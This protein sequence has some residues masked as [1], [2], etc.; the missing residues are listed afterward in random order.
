MLEWVKTTILNSNKK[1]FLMLPSMILASAIILTYNPF[2]NMNNINNF[3]RTLGNGILNGIDVI[4]RISSIIILDIILVPLI[5]FF[6]W[7]ILNKVCK[8]VNE[9]KQE[10]IK[11]LNVVSTI[12]IMPMA[13][14]H[15]NR[16]SNP[17]S[18]GIEVNLPCFIILYLISYLW[19]NTKNVNLNFEK[20]KWCII[21]AMPTSIFLMLIMSKMGLVIRGIRIALFLNSFMFMITNSFIVGIYFF[22]I[23]KYEKKLNFERIKKSYTLFM[24]SP[25]LVSICLEIINILNQHHIYVTSKLKFSIMVYAIM[26]IAF[27]ASYIKKCKTINKFPF[28]KYYYPIILISLSCIM[29]QPNIQSIFNTDFFEQSNHGTA[30]NQLFRFGKIPLIE[31]FD[32]HMLQNQIGSILYGILNNDYSGAV[33][34]GY[35]L[36]PIFVFIYYIL[37]AKFFDRDISFFIMMIFPIMSE[38]TFVLFPLLPLVIISFLY[39]LKNKTYLSYILYWIAIAIT[40]LFRLDMGFTLVFSTIVAWIVSYFIDKK[41]IHIKKIFISCGCVLIVFGFIYLIICSIKNISPISRVIEFLRLCQSNVNWGYSSLG[42]ISTIAF[43]TCYFMIPS[44][45]IILLF[46]LVFRKKIDKDFEFDYKTFIVLIIGLVSIFNLSRGMVRHSLAENNNMYIISSS[47]L[48]ISMI[49]YMYS[50][51]NKLLKF[52]ISSLVILIFT[53]LLID[54]NIFL[55]QTLSNSAIARYL[56]F[57]AYEDL[58]VKKV[59]RVVLSDDMKKIYEPIKDIFNNMLLKDETYIDFTNQTL[60]YAL[61]NRE[62]P[63]YINQS[64]GLLSGEYT[65]KKFIEEC[66]TNRENTPFILMPLQPMLF[67]YELD[68]IQN[69]Y[70]YY[71]VSEYISNK[72]K[73]MF[74][75]EQFTIWCRNDKFEEKLKLANDLMEKDRNKYINVNYINSINLNGINLD[76]SNNDN[77]MVLQSTNNDPILVGLENLSEI[78]KLINE[79]KFIHLY[80][81]YSSNIDGTFELFYTTENGEDFSPNKVVSKKMINKGVFEATIPC[82]QYTRIRFDIPEN[83]SVSINNIS[84]KSE[85]NMFNETINFINYDYLTLD[86]HKYNLGNIPYIWANYDKINIKDKQE[87]MILS[88]DNNMYNFNT[89][90]K[91]EGNYIYINSTSENDGTMTLQLGKNSDDNFEPLVQYN[92]QLNNGNKN[93]Y[94]IRISSDFMWYSGEINAIRVTSDNNSKINNMSI[95]KGDTLK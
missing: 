20:F 18:I 54:P 16:F 91:S 37:I 90:D 73:P 74:K 53:N 57:D 3:D 17:E 21:A 77:S 9:V 29:V 39:A 25:I 34:Y 44:L 13:F 43:V 66:E 56:S 76:I 93:N 5:I 85:N 2:S 84:V 78:K 80:I 27:I 81:D 8:N 42:N 52:I 51:R 48:F 65:Q 28:E 70:R 40:C 6:I 31:T 30:I 4:R 36:F 63:V 49:I 82:T 24:F 95:L 83:S 7:I 94:L 88:E 68:G 12:A 62:N 19:L 45:V 92:F 15:I 35:N 38:Y 75:T 26:F 67:S 72:F 10:A 32:A 47:G 41:N 69:S 50:N 71:L 33:F 11:L 22:I 60:L 55:P 89:I 87:Q 14:A 46:T 23:T 61:T 64:P 79:S 1:R 86:G 59:E 58:P